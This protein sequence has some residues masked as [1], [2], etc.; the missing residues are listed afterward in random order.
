MFTQEELIKFRS[1]MLNMCNSLDV[2]VDSQF[3]NMVLNSK[4]VEE[5]LAE[6]GCKT[7]DELIK[8]IGNWLIG[9][10]DP[11]DELIKA[12]SYWFIENP[13]SKNHTYCIQC[14]RYYFHI[15]F[16]REHDYFY[17]QGG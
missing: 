15:W 17:A 12:L 7:T 3:N 4:Y 5:T 1:D 10:P 9:H 8:L 6:Y 16:K 14:E 11:R 13:D 2:K